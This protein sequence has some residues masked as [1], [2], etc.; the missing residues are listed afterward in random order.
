MRKLNQAGSLVIP[1]F[2]V[3]VLLLGSI[4]FGAWA[5]L[6][7]QDYKDNSDQKA[8]AAV[9]KAVAAED[10]K[11]DAEFLEKEKSPFK[12]Y[13]GPA[14]YG[15]L[16]FQYPKTWSAYISEIGKSSTIVNGYFSPNFVPD[17]QSATSFALRIQVV[18]SDYATVLRGFDSYVKTGKVTV[19][20]YRAPKVSGTLG[21]RVTGEIET[22]KTGSMVILPLRD[23]T[24]KVWT[25]GT[26]FVK[27]F[28]N[29]ILPDLTFVP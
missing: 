9:K 15:S 25:E 28:D 13:T 10:V 26:D 7:R 6:E 21:S 22:K 4:G 20:A 23:K 27:D 18:S 11:K 14:T 1:L 29:I 3:I 8:A 12:V 19:A 5:Y 17:V 16:T 24:I 2:I